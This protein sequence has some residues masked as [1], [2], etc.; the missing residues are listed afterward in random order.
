MVS[1]VM[2]MMYSRLSLHVTWMGPYSHT[3]VFRLIEGVQ[4]ELI[5]T[6]VHN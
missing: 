5:T 2:Y 6:L 3:E 1:K 4:F